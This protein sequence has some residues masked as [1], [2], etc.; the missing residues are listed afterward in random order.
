MLLSHSSC[1]LSR[2][3]ERTLVIVGPRALCA[4]EQLAQR[5]TPKSKDAPR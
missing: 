5:K 1:H 2:L 4:P 3:A